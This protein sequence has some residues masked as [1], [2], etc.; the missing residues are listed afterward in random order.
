[1]QQMSGKN[2]PPLLSGIFFD[3]T[4]IKG[5][6]VVDIF[7]EDSIKSPLEKLGGHRELSLTISYARQ[8]VTIYF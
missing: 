6:F 8:N 3:A 2:N 4:L 5:E 7:K 1:M